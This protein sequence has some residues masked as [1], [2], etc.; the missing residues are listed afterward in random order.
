MG[1]RVA[2]RH[3]TKYTY[4]RPVTFEPHVIRLRPA[5]HAR[6]PIV[7]Y[8]LTIEPGKHF[9]N[10]QQD[11]YSNYAARLV[12]L[13][14][15]TEFSVT[16][17]VLAEMVPINPFDFFVEKSAEEYP[18]AYDA[19]TSR[20][21]APYLEKLP[22]GPKLQ[23]IVDELKPHTGRTLD[24]VVELNQAIYRRVK[25]LIRLEPGVQAPEETLDL[26]CGS[27]R[28][29][30]WLLVQLCR[31]LGLAARFCS[32]YLI[33][34][35]ADEKPLDGGPAGPTSD[36]T[37]LHAWTEVYL[38]GA[39]WVGLDPTSGLLTAEGHIPLACTA[40]PQSAAPISGTFGWAK[41]PG[42][43][44]DELKEDFHFEMS[45]TRMREAPR[46]TKP[47]TEEQWATIDAFGHRIDAEL[48]EWDVRLTMG[49]EPTFVSMDDR[50]A[51]EWNTAALGPQKRRQGL[52]LLKR[53]RDRWAQGGLLHFG[54]GKWYPGESLPR[55]AFGCWWRKDGV[56]V[57]NDPSLIGDEQ[58][59]YGFEANHAQRF[60][61]TLAETLNLDPQ[62]VLPGYEDAWY[63][64]WK[65]R[66]LPTN[67]DPLKSKL[68][69]PEERARLAK[70]FEQKLGSTVGYVL[71]IR[72]AESGEGRWETGPWFLRK[73]HMFLIPGDSPMGLRLP[74]DSLPWEDPGNRQFLSERDPFAPRDAF[75]TLIRTATRER[76]RPTEFPRNGQV[77][78]SGHANEGYRANR[79]GSHAGPNGVPL[80]PQ[81]VRSALCVE[82]RNGKLYV[83]MPPCRFAED[84][85]D[86]VAAIE[87]TA[88]ELQLPVLIEGY[89]PPHDPRLNN[90]SVTPDPGVIEVNV[91]PANNW[92]ELTDL[93]TSLYEEARVAH[94]GTEKFMVDGRHTGTG[95]GNHMV[96]G[97]ATPNDSPFLRRPDLLK[98]MV[99]FWN[100][101]PSL[102][103]LFSGL[104]VGP[105]SQ[106][107]RV[108]E[109]RHDAL[110]ELEIACSQ[111]PQDGR[112]PPLWLVDR[113]FRNFLV[114][115][116]GNTHRTEF[117]IDKLYSPDSAT[118]RLGLVELRS[119][120]M[121]PHPRMSLVQQLL[122]RSLV[123]WFWRKPYTHKL[124][125]WGTE[126]HDR[127][128]LPHFVEQDL[129]DAL[130][131][132]K[133]NG[134]AFDPAWFIPHVEFR[135]PV[136]GSTTN[137]G[138]QLDL[139]TAVEPWPVLGE[140][141]SS[142][143]TARYVDSSVERLQVKVSGLTDAR[144]VVTCNGRRLPLHPT[145][146]NGEYVAG[147]RYRAWQ[148]PSCLHPTI[149]SHSPLVFDIL[150]TWNDR[151]IGGCR[152]SVSHPGG[153]SHDTFPVNALEAEGRRISRFFAFGHTPGAVRVPP[154]EPNE[155][156]PFTLD[157][158]RKEPAIYAPPAVSRPTVAPLP[159]TIRS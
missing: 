66:R 13:E 124:V 52:I 159:E 15:S 9:L 87:A 112:V 72:R 40:D 131:E 145:G 144:H 120:E 91:H 30:A 58:I 109:A 37:D 102:S 53:L 150:D 116:T 147:V 123:S 90:F 16:V 8:S 24:F 156:F 12:F 17:D 111:L 148:P 62:H 56:P 126:L 151:S 128:L 110:Y 101:H 75:P 134:Y 26:G 85:L 132:I 25:Y 117:C 96:L 68:D 33:Q 46:V 152:Y 73:E 129:G 155:D 27:C 49:G 20:E 34:L 97:G 64:M 135:F 57:W 104:F 45:V 141:G 136:I 82:P 143:G 103:Y 99:T 23:E 139:R 98:S 38:P 44:D 4:D 42:E 50:E 114:D 153:R 142:T 21:L 22:V 76:R 41:K 108:D 2:L 127:F 18:F 119:F 74:L 5:P 88:A 59:P 51:D 11:A 137:R 70:V 19:A 39:G 140:E 63:Y 83:F 29:S 105:T 118:G 92:G 35:T 100:N 106:H 32:G 125:R 7:S 154:F 69:D 80:P 107:P 86:L 6:T 67:V 149:P 93:T 78:E 61:T 130:D 94:L 157:L 84:Y 158:R 28:D 133:Q 43:E 146:T 65:E 1:I 113:S 31:N 14:P 79:L 121:P 60:I 81:V 10:W 55:W 138:V 3:V 54:E 71:P 95:G 77:I 47:Y 122:L 115:V 48:R 36:F 89:K